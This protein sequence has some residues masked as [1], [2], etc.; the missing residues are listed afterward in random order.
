MLDALGIGLALF[1]HEDRLI[2]L[3][4]RFHRIHG[5]DIDHETGISLDRLFDNCV[6]ADMF[7][8]SEL[9]RGMLE[10]AAR[11][12]GGGP[13]DLL[14]VDG[15]WLRIEDQLSA[16]GRIATCI[17]I[18]DWKRSELRLRDSEG[19]FRALA[20][21]TLEGL[22]LYVDN[23]ITDVNA[24]AAQLFGMAVDRLVG[25]D[26]AE[27]VA[28]IDRDRLQAEIEND[29]GEVIEITCLRSD[30][31]PFLAEARIRRIPNRQG[32]AGV[33]S[34]RDVTERLQVQETL[35]RR[36][37]ILGAV[38]IA[39]QKFLAEGNWHNSL[40]PVLERLG[41]AAG[42]SYVFV[43]QLR[44]PLDSDPDDQQGN[45]GDYLVAD[46]WSWTAPGY[47][48]AGIGERLES[49]DPV[50]TGLAELSDL[51][52][53]RPAINSLLA[54][55]DIQQ[56]LM[57]YAGVQS[58]CIFPIRPYEQPD[59]P[60]WGV[61]GFL[62][63][64]QPRRWLDIDIETLGTAVDL[65]AA[66]LRRDHAARQLL[67]AK[68]TAELASRA[69]SEF[70]AIISHEIRTPMNAV[71]GMLGLLGN[72][73]LNE[74]QQDFADTAREAAD[75]LMA[76]IEDILDISRMESGR[77]NVDERDF[78]L[79]E[80]IEG[81]SD[82][83]APKALEQNL[84]LAID[85]P[86]DLP[87]QLRGDAGR[88]RQILLNLLGNAIKFTDEGSILISVSSTELPPAIGDNGDPAQA[89]GDAIMLRFEVA[90]TG[91]GISP[92]QQAALFTDFYQANPTLSRKHGGTGLG[93]AISKRLTE[94]LGGSI[95]VESQLGKGA[96]FWFTVRMG[97]ARKPRAQADR[98]PTEK[99]FLIIGRPDPLSHALAR[100]LTGAGCTVVFGDTL[101]AAP[102]NGDARPS[103]YDGVLIDAALMRERGLQQVPENL[104]AL[105]PRRPVLYGCIESHRNRERLL[106]SG[107]GDMLPT[108]FHRH[109]IAALLAHQPIPRHRRRTGPGETSPSQA[110]RARPHIL[111][112]D[113]S[114]ARQNRMARQLEA[115]GF[116]TSR[117]GDSH[118]A[119]ERIEQLNCDLVII[120]L[121][122]PDVDAAGL[123]ERL[124]QRQDQPPIPVIGLTGAQANGDEQLLGAMV[125]ATMARS[126][127]ESLLVELCETL[128]RQRRLGNEPA[129]SD[130][131]DDAGGKRE[132]TPHA[133]DR[134]TVKELRE[135]IGD[136]IFGDLVDSFEAEAKQRGASLILA[137]GV[138]DLD[139]V[140][141]EA[142]AM[143]S[144][145]GSFG[146][147]RLMKL[148]ARLEQEAKAGA[149][150]HP[151]E[152][153]KTMQQE[154]EQAILGLRS[155]AIL[156]RVAE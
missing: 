75:G 106:A 56:E 139:K 150:D 108:P 18:S 50:S 53:G 102:A 17:D 87:H 37:A 4:E 95:G 35:R 91:I 138:G 148:A 47:A 64:D 77:L 94:M 45:P 43:H 51:R 135:S 34:L 31:A 145:A 82:M 6:A 97:P 98:P 86:Y 59:S 40:H 33:I 133:I 131:T 16:W 42:V 74:E 52:R 116:T 14:L 128:L 143:K 151:H 92:D 112:V 44:H 78:D 7:A 156:D 62:Q 113:D 104:S 115:H 36:D 109:E 65:I 149:L 130:S 111:V 71:L 61:I 118:Q 38:G 124:E 24:P 41:Q 132:D 49:F 15:R 84:R 85:I 1:D 9:A 57:E 96:R 63:L 129:E 26:P 153:A 123:L 155:I 67:Q 100:Q 121:G 142:H 19:R 80:L 117:A 119:L 88:L 70:L 136:D 32:S 46:Q 29:S 126:E 10:V 140:N 2:A 125:D 60:L 21:A 13:V 11:R 54:T 58:Y 72:S 114:H 105:S 27:L 137:L 12:P 154:I 93:L 3:N 39:A 107:F 141:E 81:T 120:D 89:G 134:R 83:F 76:I 79:I 110:V 68:E 90:D 101:D 99:Y 69:K 127:G 5:R 144:L 28:S 22:L 30:G 8:D 152:D 103:G 147:P 48:D 146:A 73:G 25:R 55:D 122:H 66:A 23:R 20:D